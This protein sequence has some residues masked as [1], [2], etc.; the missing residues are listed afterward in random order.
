M[1][2]TVDPSL[3]PGLVLLWGIFLHAQSPN[4]Q[5]TA[6]PPHREVAI[7]F[8]DLPKGGHLPSENLKVIQRVNQ[9][10]LASLK[11]HRVPA[12]G[13]VNEHKVFVRGEVEA[14][15]A[16]LQMWLDA[17]MALGNHTFSHLNLYDTPL[18][19][20]QDDVIHGEVV[21]RWLQGNQFQR[22]CFRHPY[23]NTG[24]TRVVK[25][26]FEAFLKAR[27]YTV[28]PAT[29]DNSDSV[30][31]AVYATAK[32]HREEALS[33][34]VRAAYL[35]FLD[36]KFEFFERLSRELLGYEV[37]QILLLHDNEIN[38]ECMDEIILKLQKRGYAFITLDQALQDKAYQIKDDYVGP[39]GISWLHRWTVSMGV[40]MRLSEEPSPPKFVMDLYRQMTA[41]GRSE[42]RP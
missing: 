19:R 15:I 14:R 35:D 40:P 39:G 6:R 17:G 25:E 38:A 20:Y 29:V 2:R 9:Q 10:I 37:R 5:E 34:R 42:P 1:K 8:D 12:I 18:R 22:F 24:P 26:S 32:D 28:A 3:L 36:T 41:R 30:F 13:F 16:V 23:L 11:A 4:A 7:T 21:T 27:N 33:R 31:S